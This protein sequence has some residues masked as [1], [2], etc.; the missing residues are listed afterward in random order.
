MGR[1]TTAAA[2]VRRHQ[3]D[4]LACRGL[5]AAGIARAIG[6]DY[7]TVERDLKALS[8][9][10]QAAID[11]KAERARLLEAARAAEA[12]AWKVYAGAKGHDAVKLGALGKIL[13]AQAQ[14]LAVLRDLSGGE[15]EARLDALEQRLLTLSPASG[16][17][18]NGHARRPPW[19]T[20]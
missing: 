2:A 10:R 3:V 9:A 5:K 1:P 12:E 4:E 16:V 8:V 15:L 6:T 19:A 13:G 17:S 7:R 11:V 18:L 20:D 14:A